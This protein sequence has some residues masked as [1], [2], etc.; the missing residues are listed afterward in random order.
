[1]TIEEISFRDFTRG[2]IPADVLK[3]MDKKTKEYKGLFIKA[4]LAESVLEFLKEKEAQECE[5]KKRALL[6]FVGAF[7]KGEGYAESS[8]SEIKAQKYD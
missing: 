6:D 8:H 4:E 7:G 3:L 1:M 5:K 2:H